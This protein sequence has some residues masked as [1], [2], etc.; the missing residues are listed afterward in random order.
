MTNRVGW[1]E[2]QGKLIC[3]LRLL[4]PGPHSRVED[5]E[6]TGAPCSA[7]HSESDECDIDPVVLET[8]WAKAERLRQLPQDTVEPRVREFAC[9]AIAYRLAPNRPVLRVAIREFMQTVGTKGLS[10]KEPE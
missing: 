8:M 2:W 6:C 3:P 1:N 10:E 4:E 7:W 5:S 9:L